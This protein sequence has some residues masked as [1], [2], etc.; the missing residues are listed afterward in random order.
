MQQEIGKQRHWPTL[1]TVIMV[2]KVL[3]DIEESVISV[4]DLKRKLPRQVNHNTLML[5]LQY[6]EESNKII[7]T[8]KGV[9][10]IH[11]TNPNLRKAITEGFEV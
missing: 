5:I 11:N 6:L 4:A 1:N 2:E 10:W 8:A 3:R 9:T 7:F